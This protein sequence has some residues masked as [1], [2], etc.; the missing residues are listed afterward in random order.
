M[1]AIGRIRGEA[2]SAMRVQSGSSRE[3]NAHDRKV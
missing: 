1:N 3:R 2:V